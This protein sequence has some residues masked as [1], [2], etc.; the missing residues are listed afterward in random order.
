MTATG[1]PAAMETTRAPGLR[2][3]EI[4][5]QM[6]VRIWGLTESTRMSAT[7]ATSSLWRV[8]WMA[9]RSWI[10]VTRSGRGSLPDMRS[11]LT[12]PAPSRPLIMASAMLPVPMKPTC[13]S[14]GRGGLAGAD[15]MAGTLAHSG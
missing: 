12:R 6:R 9:Y 8:A 7:R 2:C 15:V 5:S 13:W 10:S 14:S 4:S 1:T 11:A 3:V